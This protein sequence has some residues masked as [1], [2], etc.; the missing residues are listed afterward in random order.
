MARLDFGSTTVYWGRIV[1]FTAIRQKPRSA[2]SGLLIDHALC[3]ILLRCEIISS[4][5]LCPRR[6][7]GHHRHMMT[8]GPGG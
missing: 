3:D 7:L 2:P 1:S 4:L 8:V 5:F 6:T